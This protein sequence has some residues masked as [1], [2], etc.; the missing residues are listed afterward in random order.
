M[1]DVRKELPVRFLSK[2]LQGGQLKWK[3]YDKEGLAIFW[4]IK[5]LE[6]LLRDIHFILKTDHANL[7]YINSAP[8]DRVYRWKLT[9]QEFDFDIEHTPKEQNI[10]ADYLSRF[11][12]HEV[13]AGDQIEYMTLSEI[14]YVD[15]PTERWNTI[16]RVHNSTVG[17]HGVEMTIKKLLTMKPHPATYQEWPEI[18][19]HV[20]A[21][22]RHCPCCQKMSQLKFAI[23]TNPFTVSTYYPGEII[24]M[25]SL[26]GLPSTP[27]GETCVIVIID[28][29]T[30]FVELYPRKST[31]EDEAVSALLHHIGR[32]GVPAKIITDNGG[33]FVAEPIITKLYSALNIEH[34]RTI[35]YSKEENSIVERS[36]KE[37]LRHLKA[38]VYDSK[39]INAWKAYLPIVQRIMN[40]TVHSALGVAPATLLHGGVLDLNRGLFT[41]L[42]KINESQT[43]PLG[44]YVQKLI[45]SERWLLDLSQ[46]HQDRV[47]AENVVKRQKGEPTIFPI[48]SYVLAMYPM[49]RMGRRSKSKLHTPLK[50]PFRVTAFEGDR[51]TVYNEV[52]KEEY[53]YHV[54]QLKP[55]IHD[56]R[57]VNPFDV[58]LHDS[59]EY[60]VERIVSH[61]GTLRDRHNL[62][63]E[64]KWLGFDDTEN[65]FEPY[66]EL[67]HNEHLHTY[68]NAN[69]MRSLIPLEHRR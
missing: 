33:Q 41:A 13:P 37:I 48:N 16:K 11:M 43:Q 46:L 51:Y 9:F 7:T 65:T 62:R 19:T 5:E 64:V 40:A 2:S 15:V 63:F 20:R 38:L 4:A 59:Q 47:N 44:E 53:V 30:R 12:V 57:K 31:T 35:A 54:T 68:L 67:R 56:P 52:N 42:P 25:D 32:Y 3:I 49:T 34:V 22:V 66:H 10:V 55:F 17:H 50:G 58:A 8:N 24:S 18:R 60:M 45:A 21:F 61:T 28:N 1:V 29:F 36:N 23:Q 6:Y 26:T 39:T 14:Q 27:D 69:R